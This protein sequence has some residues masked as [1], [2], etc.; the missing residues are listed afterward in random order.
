MRILVALLA[1]CWTALAAIPPANTYDFETKAWRDTVRTNSSDVSSSSYRIATTLMLNF[2]RFGVRQCL[3]YCLPYQGNALAAVRMPLIH[4]INGSSNAITAVAFVAGDYTE[5]TGLTG[6][7]STK[8][9]QS[10]FGMDVIGMPS[11]M[12]V[13]VRSVPTANNHILIGVNSSPNGN[14]FIYYN[15]ANTSIYGDMC[16]ASADCITSDVNGIGLYMHTRTTTNNAN[17]YKNGSL[18]CTTTANLGVTSPGAGVVMI[19]CWNNL[20]SPILQTSRPISY[21]DVGKAMNAVQA[22]AHYIAIQRAQLDL[23]RAK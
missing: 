20:G 13:Y 19:H 16:D 2:K 8:Y 11:H 7:G 3:S 12:S 1:F 9:L 15:P 10:G 23:N 4:D 22:S 21:A 6:D 17:M 5:A 18:F 14:C